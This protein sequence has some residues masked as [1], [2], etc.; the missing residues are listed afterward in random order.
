MKQLRNTLALLM[1]LTTIGSQTFA[2][3]QENQGT[4]NLDA[5]LKFNGMLELQTMQ[6]NQKKQERAREVLQDNG[7]TFTGDE[8]GV[9]LSN[10]LRLNGKPLDFGEFNLSSSGE[11]TLKNGAST[12]DQATPIPFY[13]YLKRNGSKVFIPGKERADP[14]LNKIDISEVLQHAQPGDYLVIEAVKE[15]DSALKSKLKVLPLGC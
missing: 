8:G 7:Y 6:A 5:M 14:T 3:T 1:L 9:F 13:V 2:Q 4:F 11:L 12:T 15:E 10:S